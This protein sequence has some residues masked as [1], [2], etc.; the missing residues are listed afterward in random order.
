[1]FF[2]LHFPCSALEQVA[3]VLPCG[4]QMK[5]GTGQGAEAATT[6][7]FCSTLFPK[8]YIIEE[9]PLET[10]VGKGGHAWGRLP[11]AQ[12]RF[13]EPGKEPKVSG[14]WSSRDPCPAMDSY[15]PRIDQP[16]DP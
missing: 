1:M 9:L 16:Q 2:S 4:P 11:Q 8:A 13:L 5:F 14:F 6:H 7:F 12:K 3:Y 15:D 10:W